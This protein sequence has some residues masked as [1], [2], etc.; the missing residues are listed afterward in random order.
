M[1][2]KNVLIITP[3][4]NEC[5]N[6][7][8]F[9]DKAVDFNYHVLIVD[10][11][12]P[13]NTSRFVTDHNE[14]NK[15]IFLIKRAKKLGLGTAYIQGFI[16]GLKDKNYEYFVE[17]DADFS[18]RFEDL[19]KMLEY[20]T[21][22][23]LIIGSRYIEFGKTVGWS[24]RRRIL[25]KYANKISKYITKSNINDMTSGFRVYSRKGLE[26]INFKNVYS[27]GYS[28]QIEMAN[29]ANLNGLSIKEVPIIFMERENGK[30]KMNYKITFEALLYLLKRYFLS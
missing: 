16:Q 8:K 25:S 20:K 27:N 13:D 6:I 14:F 15:S 17:M 26:S 3:T 22:F 2:K 30:S 19:N 23:D 12:S 1:N 21:K 7:K 18:H 11:N 29:I 9:L 10:D 5:K 24:W 4:F 28:F